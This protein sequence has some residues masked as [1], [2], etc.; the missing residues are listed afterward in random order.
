MGSSVSSDGGRPLAIITFPPQFPE[1]RLP[2]LNAEDYVS[3]ESLLGVALSTLMRVPAE[4]RAEL[5]A[6]GL[7]RIV[8]SGENDKRRHLLKECLE[9]YSELDDAQRE[10]FRAMLDTTP[11]Q[12]VKEAMITTYEKGIAQGMI[13][14]LRQAAFRQLEAKFGPLSPAVRQRVEAL[15]SDELLQLLDDFLKAQSLKDL[16]LEE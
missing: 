2:G 11:Y 10:R 8:A 4:R 3:G 7:K 16:R 13:L 12:E 14:G 5:Y 9:S 1:V 15:S 6:E